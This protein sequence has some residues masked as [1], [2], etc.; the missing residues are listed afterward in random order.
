[1]AHFL[2]QVQPLLE[3][4]APDELI[5]ED[6]LKSIVY[7]LIKVET[8]ANYSGLPSTKNFSLCEFDQVFQVA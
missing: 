4:R 1:V 7:W 3:D 8:F 6:V 2:P 5:K